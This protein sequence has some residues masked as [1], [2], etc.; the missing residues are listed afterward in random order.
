MIPISLDIPE[1][2]R[3]LVA[4]LESH[5]LG[6]QLGDLV[7]E[8]QAVHGTRANSPTLEQVCGGKLANVLQ[9]GLGTLEIARLRQL[10]EHP[11]LLLS[12]Q[13]EIVQ[14]GGE[15]WMQR[16]LRRE[17]EVALASQWKL[18][19]SV[20]S[21]PIVAPAPPATQRGWFGRAAIAA[22]LSAAATLT[23]A[24]SLRD[25][26]IPAPAPGWGWEKPGALAVNLPPREYLNHL[27]EAAQDWFKKRPENAPD[28]AR[29]VAQFRQGCS[30]LILAE[31]AALAPADRDWL[32]ERCRAWATKL[33]AHL[34]AIEA[35]ED[36]ASVRT[37]ADETVNK[38]IKAIRDR[39]REVG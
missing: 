11:Q 8:L 14:H 6:M 19:E 22:V 5:L 24:F 32:R 10:L 30:T 16:P 34:A 9:Y 12:L 4:W 35:G 2:Q 20:M 18:L 13:D 29:R 25:R 17:E 31:H 39:A 33:D 1:T 21:P 15:H 26:L 38:L 37:A 3:E 28:L 27:A 36:V 7:S 23:I